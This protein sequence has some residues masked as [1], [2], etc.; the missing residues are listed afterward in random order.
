M[1][2]IGMQLVYS[3]ATEGMSHGE[4]ETLIEEVA[5]EKGIPSVIL[6]AI[7]WKESNYRQ[8][9]NGHPFVS[10][11]NTGIMQINEVHRHLDQQKLRHDIRY[12]IEAGADI[13][14]GRWQA[15]GSLYPT[16]GD[17]DPNILEHWYFTLWGYN[18]WLA[19]NNPNVSEDKAYQ[20]EI[21]QLI[22]DKY[23]Q[24]IT[25]IDSSHLPKSGLPK[26]GLKIPTP[27][28]Y[29]FGDL[30]DD[31]GVVFR[32]IIHH[33]NQE[34]IEELY[35]MGIVSGIG[36]DLFLPDAF[37]TKEQMAKIV[38]DALDIKPIGQE[39]HDVDYGEV[40]P[41]AK[42][43]VTIAH[44]HGMLPVD[45]EDRIYPQEFITREEALMML[46]EGLQVEIHKEDLIAPITYK[47]FK[48]IS[49]SALDSVA[50]FIGKGILTVEP[51]QSLR[52]KDYMTRG[53]LC[54]LVYY[55]REFQLQ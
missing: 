43:Y 51:Q 4:I 30:K 19:R 11:G 27:K 45:E 36:K 8:F 35:K 39:I 26:R 15:S 48:Q 41:W 24:P 20:E 22:R 42:D 25:S 6:K 14:L 3:F 12:N 46:F 50:Y 40:S 2:V 23:N 32:D 38:V 1:M 47:D 53:E 16:I 5:K 44:Q 18:G 10:R 34:Y 21:F 37:V 9:H 13:L 54:R 49:S 29:H 28:N 17:M 52:P 33:I 55:I 31:H 7:A